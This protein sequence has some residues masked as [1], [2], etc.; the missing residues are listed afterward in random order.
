MSTSTQ[1]KWR[2][3][4][5]EVSSCNCDWGC[6]C[7]FFAL[8]THGRCES[9]AGWEIRDG[10]FGTTLLNGVRFARV[11]WWPGAIQEANGSRQLIIDE[12]ATMEQR[13]AL[14]AIESGAQGGTFFEIFAA[15]CPNK[16]E[17]MVAPITFESNRERR[18]GRVY[19]PE[20]GELKT[21]PIKNPMSGGEHRARIVLPDGFHFKEAEVANTV[22][23]HVKSTK[24]LVFENK[25]TYAQ[26][27][28]VEWSNS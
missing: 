9:L 21:E 20:I 28:T 8:P 5:E 7:Q 13:E 6:P 2:I 19:I 24:P 1:T 26:L 15:V 10:Y 4:A 16:L 23:M 14:I 11:F 3:A 18:Q 12:Q 27:N 17:T 22:A 25:D